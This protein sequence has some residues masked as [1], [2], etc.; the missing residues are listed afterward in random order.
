MNLFVDSLGEWLIS[1]LF[2]SHL[3]LNLCEQIVASSG[4]S[5]FVGF[6]EWMVWSYRP[7]K[8]IPLFCRNPSVQNTILAHLSPVV[9]AFSVT[10]LRLPGS[11]SLFLSVTVFFSQTFPSVPL[12]WGMCVVVVVEVNSLLFVSRWFPLVVVLLSA[13][14]GAKKQ[15]KPWTEWKASNST[16]VLSG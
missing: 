5:Q 13:W 1:C 15:P 10:R 16:P 14:P 3:F 2:C 12:P 4:C 9:N 7:G 6:C 11:K 8:I